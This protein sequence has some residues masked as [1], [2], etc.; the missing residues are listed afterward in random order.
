LAKLGPGDEV[1]VP[2]YVCKVVPEAVLGY[3]AK[4]VFYR[5]DRDCRPDLA[6]VEKRLS[7]RTRMLVAVH[8]FGFPQ[9]IAPLQQFC[10][11]RNLFLLEDCCHVLRS[12]PE[13]VPLGSF[14][15]ASVFSFRKFYPLYDGGELVVNQP[16]AELDVKWGRENPLFT[17]RVAMD[18]FDQMVSKNPSLILRILYS[19]LDLARKSF[20]RLFRRATTSGAVAVQKTDTTFDARLV[21]QP[22][23]RLSRL[24]LLHS[25]ASAI[26]ARRR[27]NYIFLQKELSRIEGLRFLVPTLPAGVCPW[28]F[29]LFFE[30]LPEACRALRN[31]GIPAVTWDGVRPAELASGEFGD[32]DF[33]YPNLVFL[34]V[35][36]NLSAKDISQIVQAVERVRGSSV[37]KASCCVS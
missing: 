25:N 14:G 22:M 3:G 28:V 4:V 31:E 32:A 10:R 26:A 5:V 8:F 33:L 34:P 36:Q 27:A 30:E 9:P 23:S 35:H 2:A 17:L 12:E 11:Q 6:D 24:V 21:Y 18:L 20:V 29:P 15:D 1:L 19:P 13:G 16:G 37:G 7:S